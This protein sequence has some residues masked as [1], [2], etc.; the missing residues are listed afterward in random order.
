MTLMIISVGAGG[1]L[2]AIARYLV[3]MAMSHHLPNHGWLATLSVNIVGC[4]AMGIM[5][6]ILIESP[7]VSPAV[8]SFV[9]IGFLGALTTFSSFA[10]DIHILLDKQGFMAGAGYL[11][12][13]VGLSLAMFFAGMWLF[14][15]GSGQ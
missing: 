9:M 8:R 2:G 10:L 5:A 13:S 12:T 11:I 4:F 6:A 3:G 14:R 1:A 7:S 15:A